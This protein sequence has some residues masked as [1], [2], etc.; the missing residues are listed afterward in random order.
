MQLIVAQ[1]TLSWSLPKGSSVV[2]TSNPDDGD[3]MVTAAD[4]AQKT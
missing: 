1:E 2:L 4:D 3:Y